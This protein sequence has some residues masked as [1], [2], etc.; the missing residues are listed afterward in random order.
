VGGVGVCGPSG[1][2]IP[3]GE[4]L[5]LFNHVLKN[6]GGDMTHVASSIISQ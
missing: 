5:V 3:S 2:L 1:S 6:G 4:D